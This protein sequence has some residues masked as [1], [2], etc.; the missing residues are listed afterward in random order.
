MT[1]YII[2]DFDSNEEDQGRFI[3]LVDWLGATLKTIPVDDVDESGRE[4][5]SRR[6]I[7][8]EDI[9]GL[10]GI[11]ESEFKEMPRG[12]NGYS[13]QMACGDIKILFAGNADMGY[14]L[15][16]SGQGCRQYETFWSQSWETLFR[17]LWNAEANFSRLDLAIDDIRYHDDPPYFTVPDLIDR[18]DRN[19]CRSKWRGGRVIRNIK[20]GDGSSKGHTFY[21]GS[22]KSD[23]Q[24]RIYEK[25]FERL[26]AD[27]D[28]AEGLTSWNRVEFQ[29]SDVR[30]LKTVEHILAGVPAGEIMFGLLSNY[31]NFCDNNGDSNKSR[32]PVS[33]FWEIFIGDAQKLRLSVKAPD[34]TIPQK[35]SW[36]QTQVQATF[37]EIWIALG[38]PGQDHFVELING[39]LDKMTEAQWQRAEHFLKMQSQ[40]DDK[41]I[42]SKEVRYAEYI[43]RQNELSEDLRNDLA[44]NYLDKI[45]GDAG[46]SPKD[47][48]AF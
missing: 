48:D 22:N 39:G 6:D 15:L 23:V 44:K 9:Y 33:G 4:L 8:L 28:L 47:L 35:M 13:R 18:A 36:V 3:C 41:L 7:R 21:L 37:A 16:M 30:A 24:L 29:L 11:P 46:T 5:H 38:S 10:L 14:H 40:L 2:E 42:E 25:D 19:L 27:Q 20:L 45:K 31:V 34:K 1:E 43:A 32:W 12:M 17:R 26:E